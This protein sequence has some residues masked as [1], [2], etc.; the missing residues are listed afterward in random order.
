MRYAGLGKVNY[1]LLP[2][3]Q[4]NMDVGVSCDSAGGDLHTAAR[5]ELR[6]R[7]VGISLV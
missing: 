2:L 7:Q 3:L 6:P 5:Y 1:R 4:G